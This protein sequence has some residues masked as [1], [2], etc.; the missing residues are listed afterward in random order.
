MND[1]NGIGRL[2]KDPE[3]RHTPS[4]MATTTVRL[5]VPRR[6]RNGEEQPPVYIDVVTFDKQA[7]AVAEYLTKGRRVAVKGRLEYREW[8][9]QQD[10]SMHSK[11]EII[12][13][14]IEFL[15]PKD[16]APANGAGEPAYAAGEEPF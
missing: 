2:T 11:H 14:D 8:Q 10:G 16:K 3:L 4:G 13:E 15:D 6:K 7:E 5:A 12:A 9:S 1:W